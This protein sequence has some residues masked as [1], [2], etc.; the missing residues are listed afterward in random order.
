M[1]CYSSFVP[2]SVN[3]SSTFSITQKRVLESVTYHLCD[4]SGKLCIVFTCLHWLPHPTTLFFDVLCFS[5]IF[6]AIVSILFCNRINP[7]DYS[8][9]TRTRLCE[10]GGVPD[11]IYV[12]HKHKC[13]P[14]SVGCN[15]CFQFASF[16]VTVKAPFDVL[17][18]TEYIKKL[19]SVLRYRSCCVP[20]VILS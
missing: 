19:Q 16:L 9:F 4:S 7:P 11:H 13:T 14:T 10:L 3:R 2:L 5:F 8:H 15:S 20:H 6:F 17:S 18:S 12:S 1:M